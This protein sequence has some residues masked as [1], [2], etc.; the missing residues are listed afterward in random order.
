M[1]SVFGMLQ[2]YENIFSV[3]KQGKI[4]LKVQFAKRL[5]QHPPNASLE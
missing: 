4:G 1:S 3:C 5:G 2:M